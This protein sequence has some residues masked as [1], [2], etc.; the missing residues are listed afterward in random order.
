MPGNYTIN[1]RVD[2]EDIDAAKYLADH[3]QHVDNLEPPKIDDYS[4]SIAQMQATSDPGELGTESQPTSLAGEIERLRFAIKEIKGTGQWYQSAPTNLITALPTGVSVP[5]YGATAPPGWVMASGRS[6]GNAASG[7]TERA[8]ADTE[9][10]FTLLWTSMANTELPIQ[11]SSGV[12]S[13]RGANAAADYAANKRLPL[14]DARGRG[15]IGKDDMGGTAANRVTTASGI[16]ATTLGASGGA[17]TVI[18]GAGEMPSHSHSVTDPGHTH[19]VPSGGG[20]GG[21]QQFVFGA[22]VDTGTFPSVAAGTNI[23]IASAGG[24]GAHQN[25]PPSIA[26]NMII[27]L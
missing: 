13:T 7:A 20:T 19:G 14:P 26:A 18:L 21:S 6:I 9:T 15:V 5:Y 25:M 11:D 22:G 8:N 24:S 4:G 3:Q 10:L 12:A 17:Q 16:A 2:E 23:S 1:N 27:K